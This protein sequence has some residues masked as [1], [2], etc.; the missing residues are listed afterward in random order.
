[1]NRGVAGSEVG[2]GLPPT[3]GSAATAPGFEESLWLLAAD[4][5]IQFMNPSAK[6]LLRPPGA[7]EHPATLQDIWPK[8]S[9]ESLRRA[10]S[11]AADGRAHRFKAFVKRPDGRRAYIETTVTPMV[12]A[13]GGETQRLVVARDVT[14]EVE[15]GGFLQ[16]VV[17]MLPSPLVVRTVEDRRCVLAN[18]AAED[19]LGLGPDDVFE[20]IRA[21]APATDFVTRLQE[22]E[23]RVL[24]GGGVQAF[25][26]E[27]PHADEGPR[28]IIVKVVA[29]HDDA[30]PR[31][32]IALCEDVTERHRAD[33]ALREA[34][35]AAEAAGEAKSAFL[36][37]M[38]HELRTPLNGLIAGGD[39]LANETLP[40][41][42][43]DLL[44]MIGQSSRTLE[45]LLNGMLDLAQADQGRLRL[46]E[47]VFD[48]GALVRDA[49]ERCADDARRKRLSLEISLAPQAEGA[50]CGDAARIGQVLDQLLSNAVKFTEQGGVSL[51]V[52]L[53]ETGET[54][55]AVEDTGPGF[56]PDEKAKLFS[57]FQQGDSSATR[58]FGGAGLGLALACDLVALM[59]GMIDG[60]PR[61][62]GGSKFWFRLKLPSPAEG[63]PAPAEAHIGLPEEDHYERLRVLVVDD[64]ATNRR[65][66]EL[67]MAEVA[68]TVSVENGAEAVRAFQFGAFDLVLMDIQMPVMD[69]HTAVRELRRHEAVRGQ[70]R[71]P[72]VMVTANN[73]RDDIHKSFAAGADRQLG[74]PITAH[75]LFGTIE[76]VLFN[77]PSPEDVRS[78]C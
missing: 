10:L 39:L 38:S 62:G 6:G 55:F 57:R 72:I 56:A 25:E 75:T 20:A 16:S 45:R 22:A 34:L 4:G 37:S 43:R 61:P 31:H 51:T 24:A 33:L 13:S 14:A 2:D 44:D 15:T 21:A 19:V 41:R 59:G 29:T 65:I 47:D 8:E 3:I 18:R 36:A 9:R 76:E 27:V 40:P 32:L 42:A 70:G 64:N 49:A 7:D 68:E 67:M 5:E 54:V 35:T 26:I 71:T 52:T 78:A 12:R 50:R 11:L 58:R 77:R 60:E 63:A 48:L 74:K 66:L 23:D 1:M 69:G 17:Q 28:R 53:D 30:G 73:S 46:A